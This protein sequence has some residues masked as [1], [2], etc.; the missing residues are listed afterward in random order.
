MSLND[1]IGTCVQDTIYNI[2]TSNEIMELV[3]HNEPE[4]EIKSRPKKINFTDVFGTLFM[5]AGQK[6]F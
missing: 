6:F 2:H 1:P 4:N 3:H 5:I